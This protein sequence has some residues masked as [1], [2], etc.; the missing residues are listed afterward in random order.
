MPPKAKRT[1][2]QNAKNTE[3]TP[4]VIEARQRLIGASV[5]AGAAMVA[6]TAGA[7]ACGRSTQCKEL[8]TMLS[9]QAAAAAKK[10]SKLK[11]VAPSKQL[12]VSRP[13]SWRYE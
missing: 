13:M 6:A 1:N 8:K 3:P 9:K 12:A 5:V 11:R 4:A 7:F 2:K 10:L